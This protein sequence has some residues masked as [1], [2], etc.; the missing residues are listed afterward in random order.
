VV[1]MKVRRASALLLLA[2]GLHAAPNVRLFTPQQPLVAHA[3]VELSDAQRHYVASVMRMRKGDSLVVFNGEQGE[4]VASIDALDKKRC[5]LSVKD[6]QL[7]PQPP[8]SPA[9]PTLLFAV[10]KGARLPTLVEKAVELGAGALRPVVTRHCAARKLNIERMQMVA[11][12]ASEQSRRL[13]VPTLSH[14]EPLAKALAGWD[15]STPLLVCDERGGAR[16][17]GEVAREL[18]TT[19]VGVLVGPEGGFADDEFEAI[20]ALG[21]CV[22]PVSLGEQILRAETAALA[23]LAV[24]ACR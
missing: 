17:L 23:A 7:R 5:Q 2:R 4:W 13:T 15:P 24:L 3:T 1:V 18:G 16:M 22:Q 9:G 6:E 8:A 19:E 10:L 21:A 12:E 11:T 20:D 14:P